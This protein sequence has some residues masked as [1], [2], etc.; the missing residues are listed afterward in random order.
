MAAI[1]DM[2]AESMKQLVFYF[3]W[4]VSIPILQQPQ[5]GNASE[6]Y[7]AFARDHAG[8][9]AGHG[10]VVTVGKHRGLVRPS[11]TVRVFEQANP[12]GLDQQILPID[13]AVTVVIAKAAR[14]Q[15]T[16]HFVNEL[17]VVRGNHSF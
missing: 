13:L 9:D 7:L 2:H 3:G 10:R 8:R 14:P 12:L 11:V 17:P 15:P 4:T 16:S 1:A 6:P 5:V